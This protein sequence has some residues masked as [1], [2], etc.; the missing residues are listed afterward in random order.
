M[1]KRL[2]KGTKQEAMEHLS[3]NVP[4]QEMEEHYEDNSKEI[5]RI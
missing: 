4:E 1:I 3:D 2:N 5:Y